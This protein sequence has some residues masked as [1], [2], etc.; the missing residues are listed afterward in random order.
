MRWSYDSTPIWQKRIT[1]Y[2]GVELTGTNES[3]YDF[4]L[5]DKVRRNYGI[6]A[7]PTQI[8]WDRSDSLLNPT[9]GYRL[10]LNVSPETSVQG[11]VR[12]YARTQAEADGYFP[13]GQSIVL[14]GKVRVGSILGIARDD[15]APSRRYYGG[16]GGSV[17]GYGY[18]RLGPFDPKGNPVGGRSFNEAAIEVRYRF[19]D[20]G[21]VPFLDAG[22]AYESSAPKGSNLRY[23]AG[24]GGRLYTNF[25]PL[26]FD[27][28]TPLNRRPGDSKIA[29]YISIG[30]AF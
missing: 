13:F 17:R 5:R 23:G 30:Q 12:P 10:K 4:G 7:L 11:S 18:Q 9:R 21:I 29:L 28:A 14:A 26:R 15:L 19:G 3:V 22:N 1:Y 25:G 24:I 2:Y 6:L 16:G 27:V 8:Q 20:F